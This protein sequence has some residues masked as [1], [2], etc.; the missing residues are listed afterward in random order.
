MVIVTV[1]V[2]AQDAM[3][4][5]APGSFVAYRVLPWTASGRARGHAMNSAMTHPGGVTTSTT[6]SNFVMP[7]ARRWLRHMLVVTLHF[8]RV[9]DP[10]RDVDA[11]T[12]AVPPVLLSG[13]AVQRPPTASCLS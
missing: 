3:T 10:R 12:C 9:R 2:V 6:I 4:V 13:V 5:G 11:A 8:T 1:V 7:E